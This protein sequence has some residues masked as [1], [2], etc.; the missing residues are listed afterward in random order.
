[1]SRNYL[2]RTGIMSLRMLTI[3]LLIQQILA[4]CQAH[5]ASSKERHLIIPLGLTQGLGQCLPNGSL[6]GR[7]CVNWE[8]WLESN[9]DA[10]QRQQKCQFSRSAVSDSLRPHGPQNCGLQQYHFDMLVLNACNLCSVHGT[11]SLF[12]FPF[13]PFSAQIR[14]VKAF[15]F[16]VHLKGSLILP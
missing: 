11:H 16:R 3:S 4:N 14:Y 2:G 10:D 12:F 15:A 8:S 6:R 9:F 7:S 13:L 5:I 1:M